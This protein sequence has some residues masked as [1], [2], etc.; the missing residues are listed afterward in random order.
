M[1][2]DI[3]FSYTNNTRNEGVYLVNVSDTGLFMIEDVDSKNSTIL[4]ADY[5]CGK[6]IVHHASEDEIAIYNPAFI[7]AGE[8]NLFLF[9]EYSENKQKILK[10]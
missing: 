8:I 1:I 7:D 9:V 6:K 3:L 10:S 4:L 2:H 5:I